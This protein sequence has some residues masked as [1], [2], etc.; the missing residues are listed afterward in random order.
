MSISEAKL[1]SL[2]RMK[3]DTSWVF[4]SLESTWICEHYKHT[5]TSI[6]WN[7]AAYYLEASFIQSIHKQIWSYIQLT[8]SYVKKF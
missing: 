7:T 5:H 2:R 8:L 4:E 1:H 6:S 3:S